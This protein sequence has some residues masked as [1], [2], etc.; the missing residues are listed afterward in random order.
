MQN[1][2][3]IKCKFT[4]YSYLQIIILY[5]RKKT[6]RARNTAPRGYSTGTGGVVSAVMTDEFQK[7]LLK[8][9]PK[10]KKKFTETY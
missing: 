2:I 7:D 6:K 3:K 9:F 4:I 1:K 10:N 8:N 5:N